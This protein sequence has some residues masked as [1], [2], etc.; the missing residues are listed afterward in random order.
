MTRIRPIPIIL[1]SLF[2]LILMAKGVFCSEATRA[3]LDGISL[4]KAENYSEAALSFS[5]IA[6]SGVKN[7]KLFYNLGNA[8]LKNNEL[9][10][11]ILWYE[12]AL[13]LSPNDPDLKFNYSYALSLIKDA[14]EEKTGI[15]R[16]LFFW[17]HLLNQQTVQWIGVLINLLLWLFFVLRAV[18][19]KPAHRTTGYLLL[20][21]TMVFAATAVYNH[22]ETAYIKHAIILPSQTSVRSGFADD[23][24]ELFVLHA[25]TKVKIER[26]T[27]DFFRIYFSKGKIGWIKQSEA[28]V[29]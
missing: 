6:D 16:V 11:A 8:H 18:W 10:R 27:D 14:P 24:T 20:A 26:K 28:G 13:K 3:F 2:V 5:K 7:G 22:Y 9:G 17:K 19:K 25:G 1:G 29:I 12:R 15:L 4:Y 23:A 21:I